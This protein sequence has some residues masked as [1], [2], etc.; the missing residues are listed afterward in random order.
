MS[1]GQKIT[2]WIYQHQKALVGLLML[3]ALLSFYKITQLGIDNSMDIWFLEDDPA[4]VEYQ[5]YLNSYENHEIMLL[6]VDDE[7]SFFDDEARIRLLDLSLDLQEIAGIYRTSSFLDFISHN[8][9]ISP[10][11]I[12]SHPMIKDRM[13]S[14]DGK[15]AAIYLEFS[16]DMGKGQV[17][18]D[19]I[20]TIHDLMQGQG[21]YHMAGLGVIYEAL[22]QIA[23]HQSSF[24][25][26]ATFLVVTI[27]LWRLLRNLQTLAITLFIS[28]ISSVLLLALLV[29][30]G[31]NIN[32]VTMIIPTLIFVISVSTCIHIFRKT[33]LLSP[34]ISARQRVVE[35]VGVMFKPVMLSAVTSA[36]GFLAL[37]SSKMQIIRDLGVFTSAGLIISFICT[38]TLSIYFISRKNAHTRIIEIDT[39]NKL[40]RKVS[41]IAFNYPTQIIITAILLVIISI[42]GI[43]RLNVDT[44]TLEMLFDNHPVKIDS[45]AIE[46]KIGSYITVE[47]VVKSEQDLFNDEAFEK[48]HQW[49]QSAIENNMAIW[50]FSIPELS[51]NINPASPS[52]N[53]Q[54]L[55]LLSRLYGAN[56]VWDKYVLNNNE[57][58]VTFGVPMQSAN[59]VAQTVSSI[60]KLHNLPDYINVSPSGYMPLYSK[61]M[62]YVV[63]TQ[64]ISF[65]IAFIV[66][67]IVIASSFRSLRLFLLSIPSNVLPILFVLGLMGLV[68]INLDTAT[69]TIAAILIGLVVDDTIHFIHYYRIQRLNASTSEAIQKTMTNIGYSITLSSMAFIIGM[70]V[71]VLA[72][73]KSIVW[74]GLLIACGMLFAF[75]ADM[76][77]LPAILVLTDKR[78]LK[79]VREQES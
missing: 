34:D 12:L 65:G 40:V 61:M 45:K 72:T 35:G 29:V 39:I 71:L 70:L 60:E 55:K 3:L 73:V 56:D 10:E 14:T 32:I 15:S 20:N 33:S 52:S 67:F 58:R 5:R 9:N 59:N 51:R 2:L 18:G 62:D 24:L 57:I 26:F 16:E 64:V 48:I 19:V 21:T 36:V 23:I 27:L 7:R 28:S 54:Q 68:G 69:V 74:F 46:K 4:Y 41:H 66:I 13:L 22:N 77:V 6:V 63:D 30:S 11:E 37:T 43:T 44:Y 79:D 78:R 42:Y 50:S 25:F 76:M 53:F 31:K 75:I 47:F 38:I 17:R 1:R 8:E 49:E